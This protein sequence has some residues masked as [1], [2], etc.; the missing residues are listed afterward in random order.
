MSNDSTLQAR[1]KE[2]EEL[3]AALTEQLELAAEKLDR[4]H[5]TGTSRG[6]RST[7]GFSA[8]LTERQESLV[9]DLQRAVQQWEEMQTGSQLAHVEVQ[10]SE[11]HDLIV[12]E[13]IGGAGKI[14]QNWSGNPSA[15]GDDNRAERGDEQSAKEIA[16]PAVEDATSDQPSA[17]E[18][19]KADLLKG[20]GESTDPPSPPLAKGGKGAPVAF[21][22]NCTESA[23]LDESA[24]PQPDTPAKR[25]DAPQ[26]V[27]FATADVAVL[28]R[29]VEMRDEYIA[30]LVQKPSSVGSRSRLPENW[31]EL[32]GAPEELCRRIE[33]LQS[34]LE[35]SLRKSEV[36]FSLER[37]RLGREEVRI[38]QLEEN[39]RK[40]MRQLGI[41]PGDDIDEANLETV[42]KSG[43]GSRW[44]RM[45]GIGRD[46]D[47]ED[48]DE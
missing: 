43:S 45:L 39:V 22:A 34:E 36:E 17:W 33:E 25:V 35:D 19:I 18:A 29:A 13:L 2:K 44:L 32:E 4:L 23:D 24:E 27:D 31:A 48:D 46:G 28:K 10:L 21:F 5:R 15:E 3:V 40:T 8:E 30:Y 1:L 37:A 7:G 42:Q 41:Q 14:W 47:D 20:E 26:P 16:P 9:D 38:L 6:G 12:N 11:L